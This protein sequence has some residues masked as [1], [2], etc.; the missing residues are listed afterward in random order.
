MWSFLSHINVQQRSPTAKNALNN[1]EDGMTHPILSAC[2]SPPPLYSLLSGSMNAE[3]MVDKMEAPLSPNLI[4]PL[5][6]LNA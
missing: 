6:P 3:S 5:P 1:E 4:Q 2:L